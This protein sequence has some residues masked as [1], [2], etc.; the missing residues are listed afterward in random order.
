MGIYSF[1]F[2]ISLV[3]T[4]IWFAINSAWGVEYFERLSKNDVDSIRTLT[5]S[6]IKYIFCV[7]VIVLLVLPEAIR[8]VAAPEYFPGIVYSPIIVAGGFMTFL[9]TI[10]SIHQ[11]YSRRTVFI[12]IATLISAAANVGLNFLLIPIY[13]ALGAA[14]A[15][16]ISLSV[17][18]LAHFLFSGIVIGNFPIRFSR[19]AIPAALVIC[20]TIFVYIFIDYTWIRLIMA[21]VFGI[22][23]LVSFLR[24]VKAGAGS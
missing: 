14:I 10:S 12:P 1:I 21:A 13:G 9:Y 24:Y 7:Y 8:L 16:I 4:G 17:L 15:F 3:P 2:N 6:Y 23:S 19:M 20:V 11:T 18:F 5:Y 22:I